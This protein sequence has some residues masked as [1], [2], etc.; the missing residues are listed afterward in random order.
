MLL[1]FVYVKKKDKLEI[2]PF[3]KMGGISNLSF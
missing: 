3:K 2:S 1:V